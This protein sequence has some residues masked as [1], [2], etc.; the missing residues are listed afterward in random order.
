MQTSQNQVRKGVFSY[1]YPISFQTAKV[2]KI[3]HVCKFFFDI[4]K[5]VV[6]LHFE[7]N[8]EESI[9]IV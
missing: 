4:A 5:K 8:N 7:I 3:R 9:K 6:F 2:L 1:T